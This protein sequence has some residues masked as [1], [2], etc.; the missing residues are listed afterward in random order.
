MEININFSGGTYTLDDYP[1]IKID[2][3]LTGSGTLSSNYTIAFS[4]TPTAGKT[5]TFYYK[6]TV[7]KASYNFNIL[8]TNLSDTQ[9][10]RESTITAVYNGVSW[11]L[12]IMPNTQSASWLKPTDQAAGGNYDV[13][14]APVSFESGEQGN[15][16]IYLP[17]A[18]TIK[19][20]IF[21]ATKTLSG[22]DNGNV[23]MDDNGGA[24]IFSL[25]VPMSTIEGTSVQNSS[26]NYSYTPPSGITSYVTLRQSKTT[27]GGKGTVA[28]IT[29]RT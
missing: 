12:N 5:F 23:S 27:A 10:N 19:A 26:V 17:Y 2:Y 16:K 14:T 13:I 29:E 11:E 9:L 20:I 15:A 3:T 18:C 7:N 1:Q 22:T 25:T 24:T 28:F 6:A 21:T 8:G 4:G